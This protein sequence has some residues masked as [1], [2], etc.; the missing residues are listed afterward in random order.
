MTNLQDF[1]N[2]SEVG[3]I[4]PWGK[5]TAPSGYLMFHNYKVK[6]RKD[7]MEILTT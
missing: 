1:T 4:K 7:M 5:A 6:Q 3:T 2:R